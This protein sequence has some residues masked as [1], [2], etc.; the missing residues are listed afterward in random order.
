VGHTSAGVASLISSCQT[1]LGDSQCSHWISESSNSPPSSSSSTVI[2]PATEAV[3]WI[4][5]GPAD[6]GQVGKRGIRHG[7][8]YAPVG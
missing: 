6:H 3:R 5:A 1:K 7:S 8:E 4:T 2:L